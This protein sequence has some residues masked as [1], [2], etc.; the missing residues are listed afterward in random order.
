[1]EN[2]M[3][4]LYYKYVCLGETMDQVEQFVKEHRVLCETLELNGRVRIAKEGIN[5]TLG[6]RKENIENYIEI[7]KQN[8]FFQD[9]DWK[10][11]TASFKPFS[12]LQVRLVTEIVSMEISDE[13]CQVSN[14]GIHLTPEQFHLEQQNCPPEQYALI[15]VRNHYEYK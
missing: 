12:D 11:S 6:G 14:G 3:V 4:V 15:D 13:K 9:I 10:K 5:G 7:M 1:M 8:V 2:Y